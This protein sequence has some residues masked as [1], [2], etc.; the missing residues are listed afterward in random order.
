MGYRA[1]CIVVG[2]GNGLGSRANGAL[3]V[4]PAGFRLRDPEKTFGALLVPGFVRFPE[5]F[6]GLFKMF[7]F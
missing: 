2:C 7:R 5:S 3:C 6:L 4:P 1:P